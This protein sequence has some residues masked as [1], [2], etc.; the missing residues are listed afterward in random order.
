MRGQPHGF[1]R[2]CPAYPF[3]LKQHLAGTNHSHPMVRRSLTLAHTGFSRLL[4]DWLVR[5]QAD[6]DLAAT[7]DETR[8]G[9]ATGFDLAVRDPARL[10][11]LQAKIPEGELTA[12]PRLAAHA[13]ALLLAVL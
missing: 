7:L 6:P 13:S 2:V 8:H 1:H 12:A 10:H 3:H 5:E 4:G 11:H 9:H